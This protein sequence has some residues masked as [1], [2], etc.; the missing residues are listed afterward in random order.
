MWTWNMVT[1]DK[2]DQPS[3]WAMGFEDGLRIDQ[4]LHIMVDE[5]PWIEKL[6]WAETKGAPG[7]WSIF[8]YGLVFRT[9]TK[10]VHGDR[11]RETKS[12]QVSMFTSQFFFWGLNA[13]QT[14]TSPIAPETCVRRLIFIHE[15]HVYHVPKLTLLT[16]PNKPISLPKQ[17][18]SLSPTSLW[19]SDQL[20][21]LWS[22]GIAW[23]DVSE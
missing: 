6:F 5:H 2:H 13:T 18:T 9:W 7:F 3:V 17:P 21:I 20:V 19:A 10:Q 16:L 1:S 22:L 4:D 23:C 11:R 8:I 15:S 12:T 14:A